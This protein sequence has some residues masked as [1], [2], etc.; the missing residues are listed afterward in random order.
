MKKYFSTET[1][2]GFLQSVDCN[3]ALP[4]R[5]CR[6]NINTNICQSHPYIYNL[7]CSAPQ[8]AETNE[9]ELDNSYDYD[10]EDE[11]NN[12]E[13][14]LKDIFSSNDDFGRISTEDF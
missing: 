4:A 3:G 7:F 9:K 10:N 14:V 1:R 5:D 6:Y 2:F 12:R 13:Q 8:F 11:E